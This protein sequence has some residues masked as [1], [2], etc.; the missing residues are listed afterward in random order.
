MSS[1]YYIDKKEFYD[2]IVAYKKQCAEAEDSG[3]PLPKMND[4]L[5]K[6]LIDLA[7][8]ISYKPNFRSYPYREEMIGDGIENG[9]MAM[10][11]FDPQKSQNPYG[12]FTTI[13][14]YAYLRRIK[15]ERMQLYRK[16]KAMHNSIIFKKLAEDS[17]HNIIDLDGESIDLDYTND[18]IKN[19]EEGLERDRE[20]QRQ[21][22]REAKERDGNSTNN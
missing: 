16:Y 12:Y 1:N 13:I 5:G 22:V 21:R 6:C 15:K 18:F 14:H 10:K 2:A 3:S 20:K 4:Y 7:T 17:D 11:S 8:R 9:I 19:I